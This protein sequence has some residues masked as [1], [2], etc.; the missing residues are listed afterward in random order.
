MGYA[1]FF[2]SIDKILNKYLVT[3]SLVEQLTTSFMNGLNFFERDVWK[4][5]LPIHLLRSSGL[6]LSSSPGFRKDETDSW[7]RRHE[8]SVNSS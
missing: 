8:S 2:R 6:L 5:Y 3:I 7:F 4:Y 1:S